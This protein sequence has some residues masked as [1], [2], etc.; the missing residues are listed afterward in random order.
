MYYQRNNYTINHMLKQRSYRQNAKIIWS[1]AIHNIYIIYTIHV[2]EVI[3]SNC[4]IALHG[5]FFSDYL[6]MPKS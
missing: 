6:K 1:T 3:N 4:L 5:S 2:K